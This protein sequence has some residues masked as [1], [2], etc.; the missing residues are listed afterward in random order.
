MNSPFLPLPKLPPS[1]TTL[2]DS[3]DDSIRPARASQS[4][5]LNVEFNSNRP[6]TSQSSEPK[7]KK[8]PFTSHDE[9]AKVKK[10]VKYSTSRE[11]DAGLTVSSAPPSNSQRI[12]ANKSSHTPLPQPSKPHPSPSG[13][14]TP[15][16]N[17]TAA[18]PT[19]PMSSSLLASDSDSTSEQEEFYDEPVSSPVASPPKRRAS[20]SQPVD[21]NVILANLVHDYYHIENEK[22]PHRIIRYLVDNFGWSQHKVKRAPVDKSGKPL[23]FVSNRLPNEEVPIYLQPKRVTKRNGR[24]NYEYESNMELN[25]D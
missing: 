11:D 8:R 14:V 17:K 18:L 10:Q 21:A 12:P 9:D 2:T 19:V 5:I 22:K 20:L 13:P 23:E 15:K 6:S 25:F 7:L 1:S 24:N 4:H 16:I 3:D